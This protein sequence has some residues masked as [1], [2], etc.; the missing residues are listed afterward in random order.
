MNEK[1]NLSEREIEI[2]QLLAKGKSNKDIA[3][4]LFISANTVKVH[5]RNIFAKLEVSSR[6][7]ASL[8]AIQE[9]LVPGPATEEAPTAPPEQ[10][11][12][13][14]IPVPAQRLF[15]AVQGYWIAGGAVGLLLIALL[16]AWVFRPAQPEPVATVAAPVPVES[17][18]QELPDLPQARAGLAA[19][20]FEEQI[21]VL[22]GSARGAPTGAADRYDPAAGEWTALP[23]KPTPV[24]DVQAAVLGGLIYVPG[25][26]GETGV[27]GIVEV[28]NPRTD[29]WAT[30][31]P[32]PAAVSAYSLVAFE[33]RLYLFGGWDGSQPF[34]SVYSYS[35]ESDL[36]SSR[37]DL[38]LA[39]AFTGATVH[40]GR[41]YLLGGFDGENAV[42]T[43]FIYNP[44]DDTAGR[45]PWSR[46]ASLPDP[47]Y[48]MGVVSIADKI[49]LIGGRGNGENF[50]SQM[51]YTPQIDS[52]QTFENPL[53]ETWS[54]FGSAALGT[55][56][57][58]FGGLLGGE[59]VQRSL[60]YKVLFVVVIPVV[61]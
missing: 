12:L 5:V 16:A 1:Q 36:W 27:T 32:L 37:A 13:E 40:A 26:E 18:W 39:L 35:P 59:P 43:T 22:G 53:A 3:G 34:E 2:L 4:D 44:A 56:I 54:N 33:G 9:G 28:Y 38:P 58:S 15:G 51:E 21:Y 41:I 42:D 11:I 7:E 46:A 47:R 10:P 60:S 55:E 20:S 30:A 52:W 57:Y 23:S 49:H 19:V 48:A 14:E 61:R 24:R 25:G 45:D 50:F 8:V 31:S 29:T 6:T 17:Q